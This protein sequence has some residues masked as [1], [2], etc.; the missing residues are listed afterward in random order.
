MRTHRADG[1]RRQDMGL[2]V[3]NSGRATGEWLVQ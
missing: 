2:V 1:I 3:P